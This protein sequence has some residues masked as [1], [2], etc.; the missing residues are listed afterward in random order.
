MKAIGQQVEPGPDFCAGDIEAAVARHRAFQESLRD[1]DV[2]IPYQSVLST[3][4]PSTHP[5]CTRIL[6][7][8]L[9]VVQVMGYL[10]QHSRVLNEHG[11]ILANVND[12]AIARELV[13]GPLHMALGLGPDLERWQPILDRLPAGG[14]FSTSEAAQFMGTGNRKTTNK[15]LKALMRLGVVVRTHPSNSTDAARWCKAPNKN[16]FEQML[17]TVEALKESMKDK[18]E[19]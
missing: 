18:G 13:L 2:R 8:V 16:L 19:G 1:F 5:S 6:K 12:Y 11:Q 3:T 7:Q 9:T 15:Y 4:I 17:P 14:E 10:H